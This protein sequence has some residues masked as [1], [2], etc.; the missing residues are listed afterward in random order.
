MRNISLCL[1]TPYMSNPK[2]SK[3]IFIFLG[4]KKTAFMEIWFYYVLTT[5]LNRK[6]FWLF[7]VPWI[8]NILQFFLSAN[9]IKLLNQWIYTKTL[10][11]N[12]CTLLTQPFNQSV[13]TLKPIKENVF[14]R[15]DTKLEK[16]NNSPNYRNGENF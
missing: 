12:G 15:I 11:F 4:Y 14:L 3:F 5:M 7:S 16:K 8:I 1:C 9:L 2:Y 6:S 10:I 13:L